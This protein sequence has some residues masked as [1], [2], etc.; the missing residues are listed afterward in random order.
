MSRIRSPSLYQQWHY[1][2]NLLNFLQCQLW[3]HGLF[4]ACLYFEKRSQVLHI[5]HI[6]RVSIICIPFDS[7]WHHHHS[8]LPVASISHYCS[9]QLT[10]TA[11]HAAPWNLKVSQSIPHAS[12]NLQDGLPRDPLQEHISWSRYF[13]ELLHNDAEALE[14]ER[15]A[16]LRPC[17]VSPFA[18]LFR[19]MQLAAVF[20]WVV[21]GCKHVWSV[22]AA[23]PSSVEMCS[24]NKFLPQ[25]YWKFHCWFQDTR[26]NRLW[27]LNLRSK[28]RLS[29]SY[30]QPRG[31]DTALHTFGLDGVKYL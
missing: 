12:S 2:I 23:I 1:W 19:W 9:L 13:P 18:A 20:V 24:G 11:L 30:I 8:H 21:V 6:R 22:A 5:A 29:R 7:Y 14:L 31:S 16:M 10:P 3:S 4:K 25:R 15:K 28:Q 27:P 17:F 26:N